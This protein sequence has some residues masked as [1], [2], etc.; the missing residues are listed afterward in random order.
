M[1]K[2]AGCGLA[3]AA[4]A[5]MPSIAHAGTASAIGKASLTVIEKCEI[6]GAA[7]SLGT[8]RSTDAVEA[9]GAQLD[10]AE[11]DGGGQYVVGAVAPGSM[12]LG[13]VNYELGLPYTID[14]KGSEAGQGNLRIPLLNGSLYMMALVKKVG[15]ATIQQD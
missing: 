1:K 11:L 13:T 4:I 6:S 8:F 10:Y 12:N 2:F 5:A 9:V 7:I 14:I 15:S 3:A